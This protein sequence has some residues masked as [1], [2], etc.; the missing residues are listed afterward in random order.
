MKKIRQALIASSCNWNLSGI[1][2]RLS[3]IEVVPVLILMKVPYIFEIK[4]FISVIALSDY[5]VNNHGADIS[6]IRFES[7]EITL[8]GDTLTL[9]VGEA[10]EKLVLSTLA[11]TKGS[12]G[13]IKIRIM[14]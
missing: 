13:Y 2:S 6:N 7:N 10:E 1:S 14:E 8:L 12:E 5:I 3:Y 4:V 11:W 9:S